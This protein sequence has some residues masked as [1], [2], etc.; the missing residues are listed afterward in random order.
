M[1]G[2]LFACLVVLSAVVVLAH[3]ASAG[4]L[5]VSITQEGCGE[6]DLA[7]VERLIGI[8]IQGMVEAEERGGDLDVQIVCEPGGVSISSTDAETGHQLER[9]TPALAEDEAQPERVIALA[10]SQLLLASWR[11]VQ[12]L[13][14]ARKAL[15]ELRELY[16][17]GEI[18]QQ[19]FRRRQ[20]QISALYLDEGE[21]ADDACAKVTCSFHGTCVIEE[22]EAVCECDDVY[23]PEPNGNADCVLKRRCQPG[24]DSERGDGSDCE[25]ADGWAREAAIVGFVSAPVVL[26][27]SIGATID[28]KDEPGWSND[29]FRFFL[30]A[31]VAS[32]VLTLAVGQVVAAGSRSQGFGETPLMILA[33]IV[34]GLAFTAAFVDYGL[35]SAGSE[36]ITENIWIPTAWGGVGAVSLLLYSID[37][38]LNHRRS[39]ELRK[40]AGSTSG[41]VARCLWLF[42]H[43]LR[44]GAGLALGGSF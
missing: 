12:D 21:I 43:A 8:E 14:E 25:I 31:E 20:E 28:R 32:H 4:D 40:R 33:H 10:A 2:R 41:D 16:E 9:V 1:I 27:L 22:S 37:A 34:N 24:Y 38:L 39:A 5:G 18:S 29:E 19:E 42:P 13:R 26:G 6:L 35:L 17:D 30:A 23:I 11:E 3:S 15:E 36:H 44:G 7:E